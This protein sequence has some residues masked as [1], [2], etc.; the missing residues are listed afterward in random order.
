MILQQKVKG[1]DPKSIDR[2]LNDRLLKSVKHPEAHIKLNIVSA[3]TSR[4]RLYQF[5]KE[6][7]LG[8]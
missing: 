1:L 7:V 2:L 8:N 4:A 6:N 3:S 5:G